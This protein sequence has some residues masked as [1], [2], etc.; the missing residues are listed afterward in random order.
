M[1]MMIKNMGCDA[2]V[3]V[4]AIRK[5]YNMSVFILYM[6]AI[7]PNYCLIKWV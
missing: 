1:Y 5:T 3:E 6:M 2:P 4:T 7:P